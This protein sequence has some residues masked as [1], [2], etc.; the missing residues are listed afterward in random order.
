V[1]V[2]NIA[3]EPGR[4][5][6]RADSFLMTDQPDV[7]AQYLRGDRSQQLFEE[8]YDHYLRRVGVLYR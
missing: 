3:A 5:S 7:F 1:D 4:G 8:T 6:V 2:D